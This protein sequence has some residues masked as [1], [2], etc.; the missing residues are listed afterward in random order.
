LVSDV[1]RAEVRE[2]RGELLTTDRYAVLLSPS[3]VLPHSTPHTKEHL[4]EHEEEVEGEK[5]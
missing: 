2:Q 5:R 3:H 4:L 1:S